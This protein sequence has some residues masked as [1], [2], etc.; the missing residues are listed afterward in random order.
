MVVVP[1]DVNPLSLTHKHVTLFS[2]AGE[3]AVVVVVVA[4]V[5]KEGS[6]AKAE[7]EEEAP[8]VYFHGQMA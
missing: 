3:L 2:G 8:F 1:K 4:K 7:M 5:A 6:P